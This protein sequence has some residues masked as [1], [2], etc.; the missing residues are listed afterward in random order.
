MYILDLAKAVM[1]FHNYMPIAISLC[2]INVC[3]LA[4]D[5]G[6]QY[7]DMHGKYNYLH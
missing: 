2:I 6:L 3:K 5:L 4:L 1:Y 7:A